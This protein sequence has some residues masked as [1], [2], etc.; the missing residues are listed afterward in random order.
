MA[1]ANAK[2]DQLRKLMKG[3]DIAM[4]TT[5]GEDG[6]PVSRPLSTQDADFDGK[7]VWFFVRRNSAKVREIGRQP[8]VNVAYA[9]QDR[10]VYLSVAGTASITDD[11]ALIDRFW[12]DAY[13][14]FCPGGRDDPQLVLI[15]VDVAT[16]EYWD[17]PSSGIGKALAFVISRVTRNDDY[18]GENRLIRVGAKT[19][20]RKSAA[21]PATKATRAT[22]AASKGS[23]AASKRGNASAKG[24]RVTNTAGARRTAT[25]RAASK[26]TSHGGNKAP[27]TKKRSSPA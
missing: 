9:S 15:R 19:A 3:I 22:G 12:S 20:A 6:F 7:S 4:F 14:A 26:D 8:R 16:V 17:G 13:K 27:R 18:M 1:S 11:P 25:G 5:I 23:S 2:R 21:T 24:A 10:N